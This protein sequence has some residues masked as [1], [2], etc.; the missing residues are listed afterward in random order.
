MFTD[1][2]QIYNDDIIEAR[3][4]ILAEEAAR[5]ADELVTIGGVSITVS[6]FESARDE[7]GN[8]DWEDVDYMLDRAQRHAESEEETARWEREVAADI[9]Y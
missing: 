6:E 8:I 1:F 3:E 9:V 5:E 7:D 4:A 2:S